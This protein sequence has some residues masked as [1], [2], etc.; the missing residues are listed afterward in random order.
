MKNRTLKYNFII[1]SFF[2]V[3]CKTEKKIESC[4]NRVKLLST[5]ETKK[6]FSINYNLKKDS[7]I[8][9]L[10]HKFPEKK[11]WD[12]INFDLKL[13]NNRVINVEF[14]NQKCNYKFITRTNSF[15]RKLSE[16]EI[17]LNK[18]GLL[19]YDNDVI[20]INSIKFRIEDKFPNN[21]RYDLQEISID[22]EKETPKDSIEKTLINITEGYL[23]KYSKLSKETFSKEICDLSEQEVDSLKKKL[24]FKIKL[25]LN[26]FDTY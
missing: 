5:K 1:L 13:S 11:C 2:L 26:I 23:L 7:L 19:L 6:C 9:F 17:L 21:F 25:D 10:S 24:P 18:K 15:R 16:V 20:P 8:N 3:F 4:T 12:L 22:W 14:I